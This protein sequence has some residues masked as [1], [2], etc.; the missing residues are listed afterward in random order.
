VDII[1]ESTYFF[2]FIS[3]LGLGFFAIVKRKYY[4]FALTGICAALAYL[5]R[6]EGIGII[7]IVTG[8]CILKETVSKIRYLER[9][10]VSI[11]YWHSFLVFLMPYLVYIK[12]DGVIGVLRRKKIYPRS[13]S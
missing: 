9:K 4:L 10:T 6:P 1:S 12:R 2:F 11:L 8:W 5:A 3:A 13:R 7:F